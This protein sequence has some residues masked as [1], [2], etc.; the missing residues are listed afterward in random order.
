MVIGNLIPAAMVRQ[1]E[2]IPFLIRTEVQIRII[3]QAVP[4]IHVGQVL[5]KHRL[6]PVSPILLS[7]IGPAA[8]QVIQY[9]A[10]ALM[11]NRY[12][13]LGQAVPYQQAFT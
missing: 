12:R 8:L 3:L 9:P 2:Q 11:G 1:Y 7:H 6:F 5:I 10:S 4:K 13:H